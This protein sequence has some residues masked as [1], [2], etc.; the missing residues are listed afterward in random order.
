[1]GELNVPKKHTVNFEALMAKAWALPDT[2]W[3]KFWDDIMKYM[4]EWLK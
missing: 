1:M 3:E 4:E 2:E